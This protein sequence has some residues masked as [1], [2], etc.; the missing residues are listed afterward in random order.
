MGNRNT[1]LAGW[2]F[3]LYWNP[4]SGAKY[5]LIL[6]VNFKIH[7]LGTAL[8]WLTL[9]DL[10]LY[11]LTL[12]HPDTFFFFSQCLKLR[13]IDVSFQH[14]YLFCRVNLLCNYIY[15]YIY[16]QLPPKQNYWVKQSS[17]EASFSYSCVKSHC[18][19]PRNIPQPVVCCILR[20]REL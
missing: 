19:T 17:T 20:E 9:K 3:Q 8:L 4:N 14:Y 12:K 16:H 15:L 5:N 10:C 6:E 7:F 18:V 1:V 13:C 2:S 11:K